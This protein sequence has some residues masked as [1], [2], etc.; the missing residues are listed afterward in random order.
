MSA[1]KE[2]LTGINLAFPTLGWVFDVPEAGADCMFS[3]EEKI[4]R[5]GQTSVLGTIG[6]MH[7]RTERA[8]HDRLAC[9]E[10]EFWD[11]LNAPS[12]QRYFR[13]RNA[14]YP[15]NDLDNPLKSRQM[16]APSERT[17]GISN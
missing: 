2:A 10:A 15:L 14:P 7:G 17:T 12:L 13:G 6:W 1:N 8:S 11:D 5:S 4:G 16:R 9:E 3:I